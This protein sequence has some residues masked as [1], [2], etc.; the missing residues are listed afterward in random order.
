[1]PT[2]VEDI[3]ES[4]AT[5]VLRALDAREAGAAGGPAARVTASELVHSGFNVS[6]MIRAGGLPRW[7]WE[8]EA[9]SPQ[10]Q[11]ADGGGEGDA[12]AR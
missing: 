11:P 8:S 6:V 5:G 3:L 7:P 12:R 1:M 10:T 4:A 9:S 2:N